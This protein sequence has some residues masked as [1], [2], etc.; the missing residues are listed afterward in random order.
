MIYDVRQLHNRHIAMLSRLLLLNTFLIISTQ[1]VQCR[2]DVVD[3][4]LMLFAGSPFG[5][6]GGPYNETLLDDFV[7]KLETIRHLVD[8]VSIPSYFLQDPNDRTSGLSP[9]PNGDIVN[10]ALQDAGFRVQ[11]LVGDFYGQNSVERYRY[12]M[13]E[14]REDFIEACVNEVKRLNLSGLNFDFEPSDCAQYNCSSADAIVFAEF[15]TQIERNFSTLGVHASVDTGQSI[16]ASTAY[17]NESL[18]SRLITMNTYY[19]TKS[20]EIALPRDIHNDG[21][22]RFSLG[23]C[24]LCFNSSAQD[25]KS[26]MDLA[27]EYGVRH[28]AYWAGSNIPDIWL[29]ELERWKNESLLL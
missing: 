27:I 2:K 24:P 8:V 28:I 26:R 9:A 6:W 22:D 10:L 1:Q 18:V 5:F 13:T 3:K 17:L 4:T 15:L 11:P 29:N 12:Y 7:A 20:F 23:V 16:L 25:V 21:A 14:G 19:D